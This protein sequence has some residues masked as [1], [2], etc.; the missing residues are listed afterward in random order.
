LHL[1]SGEPIIVPS[2]DVILG[3]YYMTRD[4]INQKGEDMRQPWRL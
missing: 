4:M 2:Q 3:L 1:A